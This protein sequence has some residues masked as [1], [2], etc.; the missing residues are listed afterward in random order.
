MEWLSLYSTQIFIAT[1]KDCSTTTVFQ[2]FYNHT[3]FYNIS[4]NKNMNIAYKKIKE[5]YSTNFYLL[6]TQVN[7]KFMHNT[8]IIISSPT[9]IFIA[10]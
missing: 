3:N 6:Y 5:I 2:I 10:L 9:F 1:I 7:L 4:E 8:R